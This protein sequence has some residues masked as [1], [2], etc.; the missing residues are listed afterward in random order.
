MTH[1]RNRPLIVMAGLAVLLL[2]AAYLIVKL[3]FSG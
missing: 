1:P 2:F 3:T